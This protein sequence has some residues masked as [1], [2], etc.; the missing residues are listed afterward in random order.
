MSIWK[1]PEE[2]AVLPV[3]SMT[4]IYIPARVLDEIVRRP[5]PPDTTVYILHVID[6]PQLPS[7]AAR[8]RNNLAAASE[9]PASW[10]LLLIEVCACR[11]R[12]GYTSTGS[13]AILTWPLV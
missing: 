7:R 11:E 4:M 3:S 9:E 5:W 1:R 8:S 13:F 10:D 2:H 6:W 12:L